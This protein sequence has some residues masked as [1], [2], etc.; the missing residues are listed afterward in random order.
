MFLFTSLGFEDILQLITLRFYDIFIT[1]KLPFWQHVC[2]T[3]DILEIVTSSTN[4]ISPQAK[5]GGCAALDGHLAND[6]AVC[7]ALIDN[8]WNIHTCIAMD[9]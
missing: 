5:C 6:S 9:M 3:W 4:H 2:T 1:M 8:F 7:D